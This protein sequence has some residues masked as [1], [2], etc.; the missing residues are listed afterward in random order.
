MVSG[1]GSENNDEIIKKYLLF[2]TNPREE[3]ASDDPIC[4][5]YMIV[6]FKISPLIRL[7]LCERFLTGL[8]LSLVGQ[9]QLNLTF[10]DIT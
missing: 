4:Q 1:L 8:M 6:D 5:I 7:N 10:C 3:G 2:K 9:K